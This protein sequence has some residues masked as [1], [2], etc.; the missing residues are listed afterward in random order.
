M[1]TI[2]TDYSG[3]ICQPR[4]LSSCVWK[5]P[6]TP[7]SLSQL[8]ANSTAEADSAGRRRTLHIFHVEAEVKQ[9][10][11]PTLPGLARDP[12]FLS[13]SG[14][15]ASG[16]GQVTWWSQTCQG[17]LLAPQLQEEPQLGQDTVWEAVARATVLAASLAPRGLAKGFMIQQDEKGTE[18]QFL[19]AAENVLGN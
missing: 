15:P 10:S 8:M 6:Q 3:F 4:V 11:T 12:S 18:S 2:S 1:L 14:N 13:C 9:T 17:A 16:R 19:S 7:S 5:E